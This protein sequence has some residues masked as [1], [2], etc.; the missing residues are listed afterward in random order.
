MDNNKILRDFILE[1]GFCK[2]NIIL[3]IK[4]KNKLEWKYWMFYF[5]VVLKFIGW[6]CD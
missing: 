6:I 1:L 2:L 3:I 4:K 5:V